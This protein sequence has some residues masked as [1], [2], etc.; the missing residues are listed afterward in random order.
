MD[1]GFFVA[2][3]APPGRGNTYFGVSGNSEVAR[4]FPAR[5]PFAEVG[6]Q[7]PCVSEPSKRGKRFSLPM[8][9]KMPYLRINDL[10][11]LRF[12]GAMRVFVRGNLSW[13]LSLRTFFHSFVVMTQAP[14]RGEVMAPMQAAPERDRAGFRIT[15]AS[16]KSAQLRDPA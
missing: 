11:I 16:H 2:G 5:W 1:R 13:G 15:L 12:K 8:N 9:L 3:L 4:A 14:H 7:E 6:A 10:C